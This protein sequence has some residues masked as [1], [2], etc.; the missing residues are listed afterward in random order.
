MHG[1]ATI[2]RNRDIAAKLDVDG[3]GQKTIRLVGQE[4]S[5]TMA[6]GVGTFKRLGEPY[7]VKYDEVVYVI[8]GTF[9]FFI[10]G[11]ARECLAGDVIWLPEGTTLQ[12]DGDEAKVLFVIAPVDW[13]E[14]HGIA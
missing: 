7:T 12:Y 1:A 2:I 11:V 3:Q 14:R 9:R 4:T 13:R 8:E 10:D 6:V 5:K